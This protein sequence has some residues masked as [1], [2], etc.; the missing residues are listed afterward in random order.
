M[1][2][3]QL[4]ASVVDLRNSLCSFV[5]EHA[6]REVTVRPPVDDCSEISF[7]RLVAWSYV[8]VFEAG[9]VAIPYLLRLP[10]GAGDS[11]SNAMAAR[12]RLRNLRTWSFHNLG[13]GSDRDAAISRDVQ[14]WFMET[15]KMYPPSG[16]EAWRSCF[17]ALCSDVGLIIEHCQ[18]AMTD[19]LLG[20]DD[21]NAAI[22]DLRGRIDREWPA[23]E[24]HRLV[25][26]A[27]VRLGM[28][29]DPK[30]FCEPRLSR[31]RE[32]LRTVADA[33][34]LTTHMLRMIERD[35]M[36][37]AAEVLPIDG[38][39]VIDS[40]CMAPGPDVGAA[41]RR[42]RHLFRSGVTDRAGL[43]ERLKDEFAPPQ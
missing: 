7:L 28:R 18:S 3:S 17:L 43:L 8:L 38:R 2:F 15:S 34:G 24:F 13:F 5:D 42:A 9:R 12:D 16:S 22:A 6:L 29:I 26:D 20:V 19:V 11:S 25:G 36:D 1:A 40:V 4:N 31:W 23:H 21:G 10:G 39:D 41:L 37:H 33:D 30:K 32:F 27:V 14:R 35:L